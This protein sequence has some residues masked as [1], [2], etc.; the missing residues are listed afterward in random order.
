MRPD[1]APQIVLRFHI[2]PTEKDA[3]GSRDAESCRSGNQVVTLIQMQRSECQSRQR[4]CRQKS[5]TG[6]P[7]QISEYE[8]SET[9]LLEESRDDYDRKDVIRRR[10]PVETSDDRIAGKHGD[11][12]QH[13]E[14][15]SPAESVR[16]SEPI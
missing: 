10:V 12:T 1:Y 5:P 8:T 16:Q 9:Q 4:R 7:G 6:C 13:S 3:S 11:R 14:E 2:D 15:Q